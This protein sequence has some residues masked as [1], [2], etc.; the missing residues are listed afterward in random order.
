LPD[1]DVSLSLE[2]RTGFVEFKRTGPHGAVGLQ[3]ESQAT[4]TDGWEFLVPTHRRLR[5]SLAGEWLGGPATWAARVDVVAARQEGH[6]EPLY[7]TWGD[8]VGDDVRAVPFQTL[9]PGGMLSWQRP[10]QLR[11]KAQGGTVTVAAYGRVPS[12]YEWGANGIHHGTFRYEQGNPELTTEWTLEGRLQLEG[13]GSTSGWNHHV[14]GFAAVHRGFISLTPSASFAPISH[15]GQVLQFEANDAFRTGADG[16]VSWRKDRQA[17]T[18]EGSVLGQ[19]DVRTGLGLPF[20][21][22]AQVRL[23]WERNVARGSQV[24]LSA[25]GLAPARLTARNEAPTP[26]ALLVDIHLRQTSRRGQWSLDVQN[27]FNSAWLDHISAYRALGLAA[28]GRWVQVQFSTTLKHN[29]T[30]TQS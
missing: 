25:R 14:Q 11:E 21:T 30:K 2:E 10:F 15:A 23:A 22:P 8:V 24:E 13:R 1:S 28:Q 29:T 12:N 16:T 26:G 9:M 4:T 27:V 5:G 7:D 6:A 17:W 20:T 3:G 18:A 19:W